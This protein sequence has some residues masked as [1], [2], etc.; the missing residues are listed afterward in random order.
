M[1]ATETIILHYFPVCGRAQPLRHALLD[2]GVEFEDRRIPLQDWPAHRED[3]G[4]AGPYR[5]LPTLRW[6]D[7]L[8]AET[9]PVASYLAHRLGH[10]DGL[11]AAARARL[12][13]VCSCCYVEVT[14][15]AG[16]VLWADL[17]WPGV[18]LEKAW[19]IHL[20]RM[21][22]RL[23]S[24]DEDVPD[25][26]FFGGARPV[27]ADFYADEAY[28]TWCYMLGPE[29]EPALRERLPRLAALHDRVGARPRLAGIRRDR[30][31]RFTG[32]PDE[33]AIVERMRALDLS[34][35]EP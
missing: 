7:A 34:S 9:L 5:G 16:H 20:G 32:R 13:A 1:S 14:M 21:L 18:D 19:S 23:A 31:A 4:V 11:D 33:D 17:V 10:Y 15:I 30:P 24:L 29:R 27:M 2:A 6:G 25:A 28:A 26:G 8:I 22:G 3:P 35:I 12:E